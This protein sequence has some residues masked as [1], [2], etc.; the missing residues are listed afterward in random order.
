MR[1]PVQPGVSVRRRIAELLQRVP[2]YFTDS[3]DS[4]NSY[5]ASNYDDRLTNAGPGIAA[6]ALSNTALAVFDRYR[7]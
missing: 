5:A 4:A 1:T 7:G 2:R 6:V 3:A